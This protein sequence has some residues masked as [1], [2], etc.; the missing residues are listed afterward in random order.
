MLGAGALRRAPRS[1][2]VLSRTPQEAAIFRIAVVSALV[3]TAGAAVDVAT[4][5]AGAPVPRLT[6]AV[7]HLVTVGVLTS[8]VVA[9]T[10]RLVPVLTGVALPWRPARRRQETGCRRRPS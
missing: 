6:D 9:M 8:V 1:L 2:P 5:L 10:F 7:R 4:T 3:A